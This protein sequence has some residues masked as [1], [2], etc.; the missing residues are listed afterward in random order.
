MKTQFWIELW[1][2]IPSGFFVFFG[3]EN[4]WKVLYS[5]HLLALLFGLDTYKQTQRKFVCVFLVNI[6]SQVQQNSKFL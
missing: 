1:N 3:S 6:S 2:S 4:H 5:I